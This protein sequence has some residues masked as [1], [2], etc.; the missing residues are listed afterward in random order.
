MI[1]AMLQSLAPLRTTCGCINCPVPRIECRPGKASGAGIGLPALT[2]WDSGLLGTTTSSPCP[3]TVRGAASFR[4]LLTLRMV[5]SVISW[6][7]YVDGG[8]GGGGGSLFLSLFFFLLYQRA[9]HILYGILRNWSAKRGGDTTISTT[10]PSPKPIPLIC[11]FL[12]QRVRC[13]MFKTNILSTFCPYSVLLV[14]QQLWLSDVNKP[15]GMG[16]NLTICLRPKKWNTRE[17]V[18]KPFSMMC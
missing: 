1:T 14:H 12:G 16:C 2:S 3:T 8:G 18:T 5:N 9:Y 15:P 6:K 4:S 7:L 17:L 11:I 13:F 10:P